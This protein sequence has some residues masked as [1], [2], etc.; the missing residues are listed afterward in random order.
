[1]TNIPENPPIGAAL[2]A[3]KQSIETRNQ[4]VKIVFLKH[5]IVET[6]LFC[7]RLSSEWD[8]LGV[9]QKPPNRAASFL[10]ARTR[11][12]RPR[13][14]AAL[15]LHSVFLLELTDNQNISHTDTMTET[16]TVGRRGAITIPAK[17]RRAFGMEQNDHLIAEQTPEGIL[18]RPAVSVPVEMYT[19]ERIAEFGADET[20]LRKRFEMTKL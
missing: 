13:L 14:C 6:W 18:L 2:R 17:L 11:A 15:S 1:M 5:G 10:M 3:S 8:F 19:E 9:V 20:A 12:A 16:I 4:N 7:P